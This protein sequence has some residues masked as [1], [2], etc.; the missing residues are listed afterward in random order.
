MKQQALGWDKL[1]IGRAVGMG[2]TSRV[3]NVRHGVL[4]RTELP[5]GLVRETSE[6]DAKAL[7]PGVYRG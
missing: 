2:P 5:F 1:R 7:S 3:F 4:K 6:H